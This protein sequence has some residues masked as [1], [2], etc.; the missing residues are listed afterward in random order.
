MTAAIPRQLS[1]NNQFEMPNS[2]DICMD[3]SSYPICHYLEQ[4][5]LVD[6]MDNPLFWKS[7]ATDQNIFMQ[8]KLESNRLHSFQN[9]WPLKNV[10]PESLAEAGFFYLQE[11]DI[12][13][14]PFCGIKISDWMHK[15]K[16]LREHMRRNPR[17]HF[18]IGCDVGNVPLAPERNHEMQPVFEKVHLPA[19]VSISYKPKHPRMADLKRRILT[20][21]NWPLNNPAA[22]KLA[23]CGLF[24]SGM[25][26]FTKFCI[27]LFIEPDKSCMPSCPG[28][29]KKLPGNQSTNKISLFPGHF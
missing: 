18:L 22:Q 24:Y 13:Q 16:P 29:Y 27:I 7:D 2:N 21:S 20:F 1:V 28:N 15:D 11:E 8:M 17:C 4:S 6:V 19:A 14:C 23:D 12:V 9:R 5:S 25:F 26:Y 10:V 3:T